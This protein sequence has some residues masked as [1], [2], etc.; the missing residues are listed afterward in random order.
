MSRDFNIPSSVQIAP[1]V[2]LEEH[3]QV[4]IRVELALTVELRDSHGRLGASDRQRVSEVGE[5]EGERSE[6][7]S[8]REGGGGRWLRENGGREGGKLRVQ[9]RFFCRHKGRVLM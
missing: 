3:R 7:A 5:G 6:G 2:P 4:E 9:G 1:C 8:E